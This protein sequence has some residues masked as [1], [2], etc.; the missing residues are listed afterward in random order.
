MFIESWRNR[1]TSFISGREL[2]PVTEATRRVLAQFRDAM[3]VET[4]Y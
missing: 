4:I 1:G 3:L 2:V